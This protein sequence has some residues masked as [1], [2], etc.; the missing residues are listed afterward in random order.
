[1]VKKETKL[2]HSTIENDM[3]VIVYDLYKSSN[4]EIGIVCLHGLTSNK[5]I[6]D[7]LSQDLSEICNVVTPNM[8]GRGSSTYAKNKKYYNFTQYTKDFTNIINSAGIRKVIIMGYLSGGLTGIVLSSMKNSPVIGLILDN[9]GHSV[10]ED[11]ISHLKYNVSNSALDNLES[12]IENIKLHNKDISEKDCLEYIVKNFKIRSSELVPL[13]DNEILKSIDSVNLKREW[14]NIKCPTLL[15]RKKE[16]AIFPISMYNMM[17]SKQET[18]AHEYEGSDFRIKY[19]KKEREDVVK[20]VKNLLN[21]NIQSH[22]GIKFGNS[23]T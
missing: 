20:W 19:S 7:E 2:C 10:S 8:I 1:M 17:K 11:L 3:S 22:L 13:Y 5:S 23:L 12:I 18:I 9:I 4:S 14:E 16:S 21:Q 6:F 15:M